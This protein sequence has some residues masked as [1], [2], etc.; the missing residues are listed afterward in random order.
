MLHIAYTNGRLNQYSW[1]SNGSRVVEKPQGPTPPL[2][3]YQFSNK[4]ATDGRIFDCAETTLLA[5]R[6]AQGLELQYFALNAAN[7]ATVRINARVTQLTLQI[8]GTILNVVN[9][10]G[11]FQRVERGENLFSQWSVPFTI[12]PGTEKV[13]ATFEIA[14]DTV[15]AS[16]A[17]TL[18]EVVEYVIDW[19]NDQPTIKS[20]I[21]SQ[22]WL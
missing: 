6:S 13:I 17:H 14:G 10:G 16:G 12:P 19:Q 18:R 8:N 22:D 3:I 4:P 15:P 20:N 11:I 5:A 2:P 7:L 9:G 21:V 1:F